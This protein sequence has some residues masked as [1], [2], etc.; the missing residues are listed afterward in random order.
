MIL[1]KKGLKH[2][3]GECSTRVNWYGPN[4]DSQNLSR[5]LL[6]VETPCSHNCVFCSF[7]FRIVR[8]R[9]F[10]AED[11]I[12]AGKLTRGDF[13]WPSGAS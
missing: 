12:E 1:A 7:D 13:L 5:I 6:L 9:D 11:S 10:Q 4:R 8:A 2:L 3:E